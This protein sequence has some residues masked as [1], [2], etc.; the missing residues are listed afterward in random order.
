MNTKTFASVK[1]HQSY[2]K[3][4][5]AGMWYLL[6]ILLF[7]SG[8]N[9]ASLY[10]TACS[11]FFFAGGT[12]ELFSP[13]FRMFFQRQSNIETTDP[14]D[15][16]AVHYPEVVRAICT[17]TMF[18][19][20]EVRAISSDERVW[21]L[22]QIG[23]MPVLAAPLWARSRSSKSDAYVKGWGFAYFDKYTARWN[24]LGEFAVGG[25]EEIFSVLAK[26]ESI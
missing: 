3:Y 1:K 26:I 18:E 10:L 2:E 9:K 7:I 21:D 19:E 4:I 12:L 13:K 15:H 16:L 14:R 11:T 20:L 25:K 5:S 23:H 22:F 8:L 24:P 17:D 6:G